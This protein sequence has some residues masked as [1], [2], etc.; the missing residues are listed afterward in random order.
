MIGEE[1]AI[2][3]ELQNLKYHAPIRIS[4]AEMR[5]QIIENRHSIVCEM[6]VA[7]R[8]VI[9]DGQ[10]DRGVQYDRQDSTSQLCK[11]SH[12]IIKDGPCDRHSG[13]SNLSTI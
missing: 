4:S 7:S 1:I 6:R 9:G 8:S 13:S 2:S 11:G 10:S 3:Y 12:E 5:I